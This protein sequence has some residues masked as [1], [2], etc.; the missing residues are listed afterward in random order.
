MTCTVASSEEMTLEKATKMAEKESQNR[1]SDVAFGTT[2]GICMCF[3]RSK[4]SSARVVCSARLLSSRDFSVL[5][6]GI[7]FEHVMFL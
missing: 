4:E 3:H 7:T 6:L 2:L 1:N 5:N